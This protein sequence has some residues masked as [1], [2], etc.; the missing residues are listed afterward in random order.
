[1]SY[2]KKGNNNNNAMAATAARP[3]L[4][5]SVLGAILVISGVVLKN[6]L[7]QLDRSPSKMGPALFLA[8]WFLFARSVAHNEVNIAVPGQAIFPYIAAAAI[9]FSVIA[10]KMRQKSGKTGSNGKVAKI[11]KGLFIGGWI[12]LALS[13]GRHTLVALGGCLLVFA[14]MMVALPKQRELCVVDGPGMPMFV[15]AWAAMVYANAQ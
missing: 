1:M 10:S 14:S 13:I 11:L 3:Q 2:V 8:G 9:V 4:V 12:L 6:S 5:P 15:M 7:E